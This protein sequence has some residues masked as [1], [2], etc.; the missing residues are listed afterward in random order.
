VDDRTVTELETAIA[1]AGALLVRAGR[2]TRGAGP[3]GRALLRDAQALGDTARRLHHRDTLDADTARALGAEAAALAGRVR[4]LLAAV[5][6]S[7]E[8]RAA[9]AAHAAGD[10]AALGRVIGAVFADVEPVATPAALWTHVAWLRRGRP[11]GADDVVAEIRDRMHAGFPA[12][13]DDLGPGA[14][15]RL[16]AVVLAAEPPADEPV[17]VRID[18]TAVRVPFYRVTSTGELLAYTPRLV[19]PLT[20]RLAVEPPEDQPRLE[21]DFG[22]WRAALAAALAAAGVAVD[23]PARP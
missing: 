19:A 17:A 13:G 23:E 20:V 6:A 5:E 7:T 21:V 18:G 15:A 2:Y 9:V 22:A 16:P 8:Y 10:Q 1:D 11:R 12:E 3:E 4:A 14:D